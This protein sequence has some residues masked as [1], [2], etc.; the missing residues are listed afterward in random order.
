[1]IS[2]SLIKYSFGKSGVEFS[3]Q[4]ENDVSITQL[5]FLPEQVS[6]SIA[7]YSS[8]LQHY[9]SH[10][11]IVY[12]RSVIFGLTRG[13]KHVAYQTLNTVSCTALSSAVNNV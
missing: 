3:G 5:F 4:H 8:N 11:F 13:F 1:M 10:G 2:V 7:T 6:T 9:Q 12:S